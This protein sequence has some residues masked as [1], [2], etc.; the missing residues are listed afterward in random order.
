MDVTPSGRTHRPTGGFV[1]GPLTLAD[2]GLLT[3]L[4]E[5]TMAAA[6]LDEQMQDRA[7][8]SLF[9]RRLPP[10][11][12]FLVGAGLEDA[13]AFEAFSQTDRAI[14]YPASLFVIASGGLDAWDIDRAIT[15]GAPIDAFGVGT[16]MDVSAD[17]P[18]L[19]IA[20]PFLPYADR[21]VL[22][23]SEGMRTWT[24]EKQVDRTRGAD[25]RLAGDI[26]ALAHEALRSIETDVVY[27][28]EPSARLLAL[29]EEVERA[30]E[31]RE[32][33]TR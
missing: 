16:K 33:A 32:A 7:M 4:H 10:N 31:V 12:S 18:Y 19:D 22:K 15:A 1:S 13:L 5:L 8:F 17:A 23:T 21:N 14:D 9:V 27:A 2:V 24:G 29:Q 20:Y 6:Y 26:L 11:R 30:I 25:G 28:V 3:N